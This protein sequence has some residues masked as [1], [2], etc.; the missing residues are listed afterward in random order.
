MVT[1]KDEQEYV[2]IRE[3]AEKLEISFHFLTKILQELTQAGLL[4]SYRG[5]SG[6]VAF[7]KPPAEIRL[8]DVVL[9]LE[10]NDYF[11]KCL[12]GLPGCGERSPCPMHD[13]WKGVKATLKKE[14]ENT[15]LAEL[16]QNTQKRHLRLMP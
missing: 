15:T 2:S 3:M 14:Y 16:G 12:L 9:V 10:G 13:F 5:P 7:R 6:G 1:K 11:D 4:V 8:I